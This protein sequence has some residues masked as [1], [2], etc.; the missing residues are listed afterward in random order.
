MLEQWRPGWYFV[1]PEGG[2]G[3]PPLGTGTEQASERGTTMGFWKSDSKEAVDAHKK[4]KKELERISKAD[5]K[6]HRARGGKGG[7]PE[8][9]RWLDA[10]DKVW[11]TDKKVAWWRR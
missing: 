9:K 5:M 11:A 8:S 6:A 1:P 10:N 3:W 4:A 7:A 2:D